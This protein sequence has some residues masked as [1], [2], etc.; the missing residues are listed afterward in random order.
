[1]RQVA[2]KQSGNYA[3]GAGHRDPNDPN[4]KAQDEEQEAAHAEGA[5]DNNSLLQL[6]EQIAWPL[7]EKHGHTYDAFKLA[8]T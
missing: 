3:G 4:P 1:M 8:L 5:E 6:Y 7:A 2:T